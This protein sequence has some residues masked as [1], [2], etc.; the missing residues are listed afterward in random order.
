MKYRYLKITGDQGLIKLLFHT[1]SL[2]TVKEEALRKMTTQE[3]QHLAE[4]VEMLR[5]ANEKKNEAKDLRR[6]G[7]KKKQ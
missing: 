4:Q 2:F 5:L 1:D 6:K 7:I 3:E